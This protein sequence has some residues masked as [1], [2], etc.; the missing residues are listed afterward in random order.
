VDAATCAKRNEHSRTLNE[1]E[2]MLE[3]WERTPHTYPRVDLCSLLQSASINE[4]SFVL[5]SIIEYLICM[6][7]K[8]YSSI[9]L[10]QARMSIP[11]T[12]FHSC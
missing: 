10:N 4:V 2:D 9:D 11:M 6:E 8:L 7:G 1:I 3:T 5:L 12:K